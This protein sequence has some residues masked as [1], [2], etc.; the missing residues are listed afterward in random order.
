MKD[1]QFTDTQELEFKKNGFLVLENF[2][3]AEKC[4][5]LRAECKRLIDEMDPKDHLQVFSTDSH[6]QMGNDYLFDSTDKIGYF[7]EAK[8]KDEK[9]NLIVPKHNALNKMGHALHIKS[10]PF[11]EVTYDERIQQIL[12]KLNFVKPSIIQS[13]FIFKPPNIGGEV[14]RHIDATFLYSDPLKLIGVWIALEDTTLENGCLKFAAGSHKT[15]DVTLRMV[16]NR[17]KGASPPL[18]FEGSLDFLPFDSFDPVPVKKG[19]LILIDGKVQHCSDKNASEN[20]RHVYAFHLTE[21]Y[22]SE[23]CSRNWLQ[24][25]KSLPVFPALYDDSK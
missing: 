6:E 19:S 12:R 3:A 24:P 9:G 23:W 22:Q 25:T 20:S 1:F 13:M 10:P 15:T 8:A 7:W 14:N 16:R 11:K 21:S 5:E 4:D 2:L 17:E 18:L